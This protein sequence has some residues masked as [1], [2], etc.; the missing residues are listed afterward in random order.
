[1]ESKGLAKLAADPLPMDVGVQQF[2]YIIF[3]LVRWT[4]VDARIQDFDGANQVDL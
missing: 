3:E 4:V 2:Y 1:M